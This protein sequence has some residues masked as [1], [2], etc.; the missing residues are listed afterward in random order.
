MTP[1][2]NALI[3]FESVYHEQS[4]RLK[5]PAVYTIAGVA[6]YETL[7]EVASLESLVKAYGV[8]LESGLSDVIVCKDSQHG[9]PLA[10]ANWEISGVTH[11]QETSHIAYM[12]RVLLL[13]NS[14]IRERSVLNSAGGAT[15]F[16]PNGMPPSRLTPN[17]PADLTCR[18]QP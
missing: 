11:T 7:S 10:S 4:W 12:N 2:S 14:S 15:A 18:P 17:V 9:S 5:G 3:E 1:R 16:D 8:G 6:Y 13:L